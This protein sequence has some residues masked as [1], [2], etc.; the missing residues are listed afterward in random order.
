M[1]EP[2]AAAAWRSAAA[3][4]AATSDANALELVALFFFA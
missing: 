2:G 4:V 1:V 3:E